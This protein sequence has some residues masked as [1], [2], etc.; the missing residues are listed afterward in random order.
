MGR[1]RAILPSGSGSRKSL[2]CSGGKGGEREGYALE[3]GAAV[4]G[5]PGMEVM[6]GI[7]TREV[8]LARMQ[9]VHSGAKL[10]TVR[11]T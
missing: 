1:S 9:E 4:I 5:W 7:T 2:A 11:W 8:L 3:H 10:N 6:N